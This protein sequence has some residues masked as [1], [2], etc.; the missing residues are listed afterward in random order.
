MN[1]EAPELGDFSE[2]LLL[3]IRA[4][5][6]ILV[7]LC[8]ALQ[9]GL[10]SVLEINWDELLYL[11]QIH[12]YQRGEL[13][14]TFQVLHVHLF[15]WITHLPG[16]EIDQV[17]AGRFV[18]LAFLT[19]T[20]ALIY[21][22]CRGFFSPAASTVAVLAFV[23][24]GPTIVHGASFRVDPISAFFI[25]LSLVTLARGKVSIG[26]MLLAGAAVAVSAMITIKV[27]LYAPAFLGIAVWRF[28]EED[29][30]GNI[31]K[32]LAGT[33]ATA[34]VAFA[35]LYL[36]QLGL[37]EKASNSGSRALLGQ[38]AQTTIL[39]AGWLPNW[40]YTVRTASIAMTQT[41]LI[42]AGAI[43]VILALIQA[44]G[45][46]RFR[47]FA[48]AGCGSTL[49]CVL[50]Y[51]NTYPYFFPFILP[52]AML[53]VAWLVDWSKLTRRPLWLSALGMILLVPAV[54]VAVAWLQRV[55]P[56]QR[57]IVEA[58][59]R[60]FPQPVPM[61]DGMHTIG[62][63]PKRGFFMSTWGV[64]TY[65]TG[66]PIFASILQREAVPLLLVDSPVLS[67]AVGDSAP[68]GPQRAADRP[69]FDE[70][71]AILRQNYV[72]HW[73]PIWV[74]GKRLDPHTASRQFELLIPG[75]YTVE[76]GNLSIDG[77]TVPDGGQ[78]T[79]A[80][81]VHRFEAGSAG[82]RTLRWGKTLYRPP[83]PAPDVPFY[84]P[85][86]LSRS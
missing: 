75:I 68:N 9:A 32:W 44:R 31:L 23:S 49:V 26:T 83:G 52:P 60:I 67:E 42:V 35:I 24:A 47:L 80:R 50:F 57:Q 19:G 21:K 53:L 72:R 33:A 36:L 54:L 48:I 10:A 37:I 58:V 38:A 13:T 28:G 84:N 79:L 73:G 45:P 16:N 69:L 41:I 14:S 20:C 81:G 5:L 43:G 78:V 17:V 2:V 56:P 64:A 3:R 12:D 59:H 22:L 82:I 65:R 27:G 71:R 51:R 11:S 18:M 46:E 86:Y 15:G 76:G 29:R 6:M 39:K 85:F 34:G 30:H 40:N 70:D 4:A 61:I 74:A 25:M 63:F 66:K 77:E 8:L 1:Q 55:R 62:S 7:G